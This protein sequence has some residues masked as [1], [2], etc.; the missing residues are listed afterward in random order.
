M[1]YDL[2]NELDRVQLQKYVQRLLSKSS[3]VVEL[4]AISRNRT[5]SQNSYLWL[6][7]SY[8]GVKTGYTKEEAEAV[9]KYVNREIFAS[10]KEV[11]GSYVPYVRH[12]YDL[13]VD[14]MS[15]AIERWRNWA[16]MNDAC[17]VY[18]PSPD[19]LKLVE[20]MEMEVYRNGKYI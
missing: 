6:T 13:S 2:A 7:L 5:L 10:T 11:L 1:K 3:G 4:R 14:E 20:Q 9:F 16:S 8:W 17:S 18:I 12:I 19:E 15:K